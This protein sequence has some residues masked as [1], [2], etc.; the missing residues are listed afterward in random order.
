MG[1]HSVST[2]RGRGSHGLAAFLFGVAAALA[3]SSSSAVTITSTPSGSGVTWGAGIGV[4]SCGD[5]ISK[6]R[7][8]WFD[9][10]AI[11]SPK[12]KVMR[13]SSRDFYCVSP[14][15]IEHS[16][17]KVVPLTT[18]LRCFQLQDRG[19]CCDLQYRQ[20]ATM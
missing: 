20:C 16:M 1:L 4:G 18:G 2:P 6:M 12:N 11:V 5:V 14:G 7:S 9:V 13:P 8:N 17:P 3:A 10:R 19:F 15:Y